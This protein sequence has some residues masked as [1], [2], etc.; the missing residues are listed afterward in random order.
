MIFN[1]LKNRALRALSGIGSLFPV[2]GEGHGIEL[3]LGKERLRFENL[4]DF[5]FA[6][7]ARTGVPP[8]RLHELMQRTPRELD[9]EALGIRSLEQRIATIVANYDTDKMPC[10]AAVAQLGVSVFSKDYEW[11]TLFARLIEQPRASNVFVHAALRKYL[12]YLTARLNTLHLV[13]DMRATAPMADESD[14]NPAKATL[15]YSATRGVR[16]FE[17]DEL[18][19]LPQGETVT[20][21]LA[22]GSAISLKLARHQFSLTHNREWTLVADNGKTY[23]LHAGVN[24][25]GRSRDNDVPLDADFRNVSRKH[26]LAQPVGDDAIL[27]T[28]IS[29]HGTYVPPTA[30]AF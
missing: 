8:A 4:A 29:S 30:L 14:D 13:L 28:D 21:R 20:L 6:L 9:A 12:H 22:P 2:D 5:E 3:A 24:C 25:V 27:L 26:L 23:T 18:Q 7:A 10:A 16:P 1:D 19:R 15:M 17:R 11:R